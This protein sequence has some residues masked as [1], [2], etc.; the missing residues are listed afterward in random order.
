MQT[1]ANPLPDRRGHRT[2]PWPS[3][4][5]RQSLE[6]LASVLASICSGGRSAAT[7]S[8]LIVCVMRYAN[9]T[10]Q[11]QALNPRSPR[12][13]PGAESGKQQVNDIGLLNKQMKP[14][15]DQVIEPAHLVGNV[16]EAGRLLVSHRWRRSPLSEPARVNAPATAH[17]RVRL[18]LPT[19]LGARRPAA[20]YP[21]AAQRSPSGALA[22]LRRMDA[23]APRPDL[24]QA[25]RGR[26][27]RA[28]GGPARCAADGITQ[29]RGRG[30][31]QVPRRVHS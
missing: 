16:G 29:R 11:H 26:Y 24:P 3:R 2:W 1:P 8:A 5:T 22:A 28:P 10:F 21:V 27:R 31:P 25:R 23:Q 7:S 18:K 30:A 15:G 9:P 19:T 17:D 13:L 20:G 12:R 14:A 4:W 6:R